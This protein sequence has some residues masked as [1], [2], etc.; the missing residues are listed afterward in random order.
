M[1]ISQAHVGVGFFKESFLSKFDLEEYSD[2]KK[3]AIFFGLYKGHQHIL[4]N[5]RSIAVIVWAG[6]DVLHMQRNPR[7]LEYVKN[8]HRTYHIAISNF[9]EED[10]RSLNIPFI[11]LPIIPHSNGD[12]KSEPLG[13]CV[14]MYTSDKSP[15]IY[16]DEMLNEIKKKLPEIKFITATAHSYTRK[17]L[18]KVYKK[19]FLGLRLT[20]HDGLSNTVVE[21]GLMGRKVIWNGNTPNAI[22]YVSVSDIVRKIRV[23][24]AK[25]QDERL[26]KKIRDYININNNWLNTEYYSNKKNAYKA[27]VIINTYND[28]R[29]GLIE[30]IE[31]YLY[32]DGV[33]V[34]VII[35]TVKG[36]NSIKLAKEYGL[37]CCISNEAGIYPQLNKALSYIKNE[38]FAYASGNDVAYSNKM[39]DEIDMCVK[40]KKLVCYSGFDISNSEFHVYKTRL[41]H[42]YSYAKHLKGNFVNDCATI[43]KSLIDKY[44]PFALEHNN[45]AYWHL[46]LNI[47]EGEG[48]VFVYNPYPTWIYRV[49]DKSSHVIRSKS[50]EKIEIN[51]KAKYKML[52]SHGTRKRMV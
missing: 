6:T 12:F 19:C 26:S 5:H 48:D 27:S 39:F 30:A 38:Y 17:E 1:R 2:N 34:Q 43:H 9:I 45:H 21:L 18:K 29:N 8:R 37:D 51:R 3:P 44:T 28:E 33:D 52:R 41:F 47:F 40:N 31:S 50:A 13:K 11:S 10:L 42:D 32:Q 23:E 24:Q 49:S 16:G 7:F 46:W 22:K 14:Y 36:D 4:R 25:A 15:Q 35:S 20:K